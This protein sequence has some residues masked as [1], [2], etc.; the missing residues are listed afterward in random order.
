MPPLSAVPV[1]KQEKPQEEAPCLREI[2]NRVLGFCLY[3]DDGCILQE[4]NKREDTYNR[5][6]QRE[7]V[8]QIGMNPFFPV[9]QSLPGAYTDNVMAQDKFMKPQSTTV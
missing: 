1:T 2:E 5:M 7:M 3:S 6:A 9:E 4:P 8:G